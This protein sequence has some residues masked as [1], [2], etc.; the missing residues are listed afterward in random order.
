M[1]RRTGPV[2]GGRS[3]GAA[4]NEDREAGGGGA[5]G[6]SSFAQAQHK[7][8]VSASCSLSQRKF[9]NALLAVEVRVSFLLRD[10]EGGRRNLPFS[11]EPASSST[12]LKSKLISCSGVR[13]MEEGTGSEETRWC[14]GGVVCAL[15]P[16]LA[17][18]P[19]LTCNMSRR[20]RLYVYAALAFLLSSTH[21]LATVSRRCS[22]QWGDLP[23]RQKNRRSSSRPRQMAWRLRRGQAASKLNTLASPRS[24]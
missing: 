21:L 8:T 18:S 13:G 6:V 2:P 1:V 19:R 10:R 14:E 7:G 16:E 12:S 20:S 22:L 15:A 11:G 4:E 24:F 23:G 17:P 3:I 5:A 9:L